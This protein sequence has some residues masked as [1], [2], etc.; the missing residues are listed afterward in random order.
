MLEAQASGEG[1]EIV[2]RDTGIG[3]AQ[4]D[5]EKLGKPFEQAETATTRT[6]EGTGLGLALVKSLAAMHGGQVVL[7][8]ALGIGT[9]VKVQLPLALLKEGERILPNKHPML[10]AA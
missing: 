1:V 2:V 7:E 10:G 6:K 9:T 4:S 3:I 5:I 8:S